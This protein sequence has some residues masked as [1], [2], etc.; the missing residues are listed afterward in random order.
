M[1][2]NIYNL[3]AVVA[4]LVR[5]ATFAANCRP[6]MSV[7]NTSERTILRTFSTPS[8]VMGSTCERHCWLQILDEPEKLDSFTRTSPCAVERDLLGYSFVRKLLWHLIIANYLCSSS[9]FVYRIFF[10]RLRAFP[11]PFWARVTKLWTCKIHL[12]GEYHRETAKLHEKY[13][14]IVRVAPNELDINDVQAI[15]ILYGSG[16]KFLKGSWYDGPAAAGEARGIQAV[17]DPIAHRW[18][19]NIWAQSQGV[20]AINEFQPF[21]LQHIDLFLKKLNDSKII[22]IGQWFTFLSFDI[23]G[24]LAFVLLL[25]LPRV[26]AY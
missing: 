21:L 1:D 8:C 13:G 16:S 2:A 20:V 22:D 6:L 9:I 10:H 7:G 12:R 17:K 11:G 23:M 14:D 25:L 26:P 19:R 15:K 18:R 4:G 5:N 24:D 3:S